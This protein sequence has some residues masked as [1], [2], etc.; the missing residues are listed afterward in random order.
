MQRNTKEWKLWLGLVPMVMVLL[1]AS[2][3][4]FA[5]EADISLPDLSQVSFFGGAVSGPL[6]MYLGLVVCVIGLIFGLIQYNQIKNLP[7]HESMANVS[8]TIWETC[9]TYLFQQGKFLAGLW[10]VIAICMVY[11]F[12]FLTSGEAGGEGATV[13]M[14]VWAKLAW[15]LGSSILG[16]L[17]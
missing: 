16:I 11:Y 8:E 1:L 12:G 15:I 4:S 2:A 7:V 6:L 10:V 5:S 17:G 9:K 14:P 13:R 3:P